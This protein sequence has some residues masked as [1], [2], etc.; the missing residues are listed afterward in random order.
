MAVK[1]TKKSADKEEKKD[2]V[3]EQDLEQAERE[4]SDLSFLLASGPPQ[5][6]DPSSVRML[7][8]YGEINEEKSSELIYSMH[9][10]KESG[11]RN[12]VED[13]D[14]EPSYEYDP[15]KVVLSTYG[16]S[17]LDMF[18]IYDTMQEIKKEC[19]IETSGIG[20]VMSAGI[21][22]LAAGTKGKRKIG[23]NCRVMIHGVASG[24]AGT[25]HNLEN[26]LEE[27]QWIQEQF[28]KSLAK[29]TDMTVKYIK[30][31]IDKKVNVYLDATEALDLG[32]VD[33]II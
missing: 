15:F 18:A 10:M 14:A 24:H 8:L 20:K 19:E 17:A 31:L 11:K 26:E 6:F 33:E 7:G 12:V 21:L 2:E 27:V 29:E 28:V 25:I 22:L 1:K 16:G 30:R 23:A 4:L 32:I 13:P 5:P 3:A 9:L